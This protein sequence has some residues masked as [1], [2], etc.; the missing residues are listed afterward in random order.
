MISIDLA[1]KAAVVTGGGQGLGAATAQILARA[2]AKVVVNYFPDAAGANKLRAEQTAASIDGEVITAAADVRDP[3][4]VR[5]MF[6]SAISRFGRMDIVVNNAGI[7]RDKS[8]KKMSL[9]DFQAVMD[10][11][12]TGVFNV[13]K[14]A[15]EL[16]ADGGRIINMTSIS[17][18][19]GFFGQTNYSAGPRFRRTGQKECLKTATN[20]TPT[21]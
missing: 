3:S 21:V 11:N 2:G 13:C 15:T 12:L 7:I 18:Y 14:A 10:T 16:V 6:E 1:G 17:G 9:D 19:T 20:R 4:Q 8:I 5:A